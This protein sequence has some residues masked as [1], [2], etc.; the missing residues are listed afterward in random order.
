MSEPAA[1]PEV[2]IAGRSEALATGLPEVLTAARPEV[3]VIGA[4]LAGSE[5]AWQ[6][7]RRGVPVELREMRPET[8][9]PA[10]HTARAAELVCTNSFKSDLPQVAAG[11]LKEEMRPAWLA[12]PYRSRRGEGAIGSGP[13]GR[14]RPV[15]RRRRGRPG[16]P[17]ASAGP[18][19]R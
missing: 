16:A 3:L 2:L 9:T 4:G 18:R 6:L 5:A 13:L 8:M 14:P 1:R 12:R 10:H 11:L 17:R 19:A 15:L 7:A